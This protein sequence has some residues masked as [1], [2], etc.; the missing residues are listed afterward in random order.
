[1]DATDHGGCCAWGVMGVYF[2]RETPNGCFGLFPFFLGVELGGLP[3]PMPTILRRMRLQRTRIRLR[4]ANMDSSYVLRDA[5]EDAQGNGDQLEEGR[6]VIFLSQKGH[7]R[8]LFCFF[9]FFFFFFL[10]RE[11][12]F[13]S[14]IS[15]A[16]F[17]VVSPGLPSVH[18]TSY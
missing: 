16:R 3:S 12:S 9:F 18:R 6:V 1:M 4:T 14:S 2:N 17:H 8:C 11:H 7:W 10:R 15:V 5:F 13:M